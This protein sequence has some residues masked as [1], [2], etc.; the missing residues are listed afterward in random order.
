MGWRVIICKNE[1]S[2]GITAPMEK[3]I[4]RKT[5]LYDSTMFWWAS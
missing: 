3:L 1:N 2:Y 4:D 5:Y